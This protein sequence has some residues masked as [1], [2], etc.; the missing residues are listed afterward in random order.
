MTM[1]LDPTEQTGVGTPR[2]AED[3]RP[4][5]GATGG[6]DVDRAIVTG[7]TATSHPASSTDV[8]PNRSGSG[9]S[10]GPIAEGAPGEEEGS[11]SASMEE[12]LGGGDS[13]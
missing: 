8:D 7:A 11:G 5:E 10:G 9:G 1:D 12:M 4:L 3:G 13:A 6:T 2:S